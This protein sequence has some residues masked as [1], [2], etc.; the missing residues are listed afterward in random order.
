MRRRSNFDDRHRLRM[1]NYELATQT[2]VNSL[3]PGHPVGY[4]TYGNPMNY[5][6]VAENLVK[7]A[8]RS[9][10]S[11]KV[12][13]GVSS[14]DTVLCDLGVDIAPGIQ[15]Y[16]A[17]WLWACRMRP[18][19]DVSVLLMQVGM[20]GSLRTHYGNRRDG[21]SLAELVQYLQR[22]YPPSHTSFLVCSTGSEE[23]PARIRQI[24]LGRLTSV[25]SEDLGGASLY[26]PALTKPEVQHDSLNRMQEE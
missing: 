7:H 3:R 2:V 22:F 17:S 11:F 8:M 5:D 13:P 25:S 10:L 26:I 23:H 24:E 9:H 15:I 18:S 14:L 21:N 20:F 12:I 1:E 16:D 6:K 4:V 19:L